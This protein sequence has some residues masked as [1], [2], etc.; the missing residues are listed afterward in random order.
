MFKSLFLVCVLSV[1]CFGQ[2]QQ[3]T[4]QQTVTALVTQQAQLTS[5]IIT[6]LN[7]VPELVKQN[8]DLQKQMLNLQDTIARLEE[9]GL[10]RKGVK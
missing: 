1:V 3:P 5:Q 4:P 10:Y 2:T 9:K 8:Q 6:V 7:Q